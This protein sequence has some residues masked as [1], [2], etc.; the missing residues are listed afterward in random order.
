MPILRTEG[1]TKSYNGRTVVRSVSLEVRAGEV[2]G[3]LE[4]RCADLEISP[5]GLGG[6]FSMTLPGAPSSYAGTFLQIR[7]LVRVR[8]WASDNLTET[9]DA[10]FVVG[11]V[12]T[13]AEWRQA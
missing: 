13:P 7:W 6:R 2:V 12:A 5:T 3:L 10:P 1:L 11:S 4:Q 9:M 8:T